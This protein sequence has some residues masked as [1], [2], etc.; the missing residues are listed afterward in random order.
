MLIDRMKSQL[1][2]KKTVKSA[3]LIVAISYEGNPSHGKNSCY[4][5]YRILVKHV[6]IFNL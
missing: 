5:T 4:L 3:K 2:I 1:D 6:P